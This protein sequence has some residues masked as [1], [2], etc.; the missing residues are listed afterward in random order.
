MCLVVLAWKAVP[1][2]H[3]VLVGN[4]DELHSRPTAA[5]SW[6]DDPPI[7]AGRDLGAGGTWLGVDARRRFGAITN[8]RGGGGP[9]AAPS[10]GTLIPRFL[11]GDQTPGAF[12]AALAAEADRY[13]GFSLLLADA[14]TLGY[15]CN[16]APD[17][18]RLLPPGTYG[19]S[20]ATLDAPWPKLVR[21]REALSVQLRAAP[22]A[23][24][25]LELLADRA[26]AADG[27]LPDTGIGIELERRL[28][29][30]FIV[31]PY[32]GTRSTTALAI[33]TDGGG[34]I[35][36][37]SFTAD[38]PAAAHEGRSAPAAETL[39][40]IAAGAD[41]RRRPRLDILCIIMQSARTFMQT[42]FHGSGAAGARAG[43]DRRDA[44][45]RIIR[46]G[47]VGRQAE[48]VRLLKREGYAVTQ[49]SVSRDLRD[50]GVAKVGD[51]YVLAEDAAAPVAE[52]SVVAPFV[53]A[54][55]PAGPNLTVIRTTIGSAQSVALAI[56]R[57]RWPDCGGDSVGRR[58]YLHRDG[59][60]ARAACRSRPPA[61]TQQAAKGCP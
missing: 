27:D 25:L 45:K 38:G 4:R 26:P 22:S 30:A 56:D 9:A 8:F 20:N 53:R 7:L 35:V 21:S 34:E 39:I 16:R 6:W 57:A 23:E 41:R 15:Y 5:L 14:D 1:G 11:A 50:L 49:S 32:Y 43:L 18:P 24:Q 12:L 46:G 58:Y 40:T 42:D 44:L 59:D 29:A 55:T 13:A 3:V 36:E 28:S 48:L 19:L 33:A 51:R 54:V 61:L 60:G 47:E 37:R 17:G 10:R 31:D 2:Q 52:L